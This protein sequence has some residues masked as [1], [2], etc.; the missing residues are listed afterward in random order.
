MNGMVL[1]TLC[2]LASVLASLFLKQA[3]QSLS[4]ALSLSDL[5]GNRLVWVGGVFYAAAF[6]GYVYTLRTVPLSLAQP[7]ITA[8]VWVFTA[9]VA[10][11]FFNEPISVANWTGLALVCTGVFLLFFGRV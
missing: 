9:L 7:A 5:L 10:V 1:L 4:E 2:T 11:S 3:S 6:V 8:G